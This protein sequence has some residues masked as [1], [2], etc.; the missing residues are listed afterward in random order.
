MLRNPNI[1]IQRT[2]GLY[3][4]TQTIQLINVSKKLTSS[5]KTLSNHSQR[6]IHTSS[7]NQAVIQGNQLNVIK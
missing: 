6:T 1:S 5:I 7:L 4:A 3:S 2:F